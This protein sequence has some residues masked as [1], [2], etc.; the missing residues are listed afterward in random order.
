MVG[1]VLTDKE[2][3]MSETPSEPPDVTPHGDPL[4][5]QPEPPDDPVSEPDVE[6]ERASYFEPPA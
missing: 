5:S 1:L 2:F 4:E 3:T 6:G